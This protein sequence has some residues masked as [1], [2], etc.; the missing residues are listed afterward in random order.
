MRS[1]AP[2]AKTLGKVVDT[3]RVIHKTS[4]GQIPVLVFGLIASIPG[5][6]KVCMGVFM[7][8]ACPVSCIHAVH[9]EYEWA[10]RVIKQPIIIIGL[11]DVIDCSLYYN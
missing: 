6:S 5:Q 2:K 10:L 8:Y 9:V 3:R 7:L 4:N 1:R 11:D